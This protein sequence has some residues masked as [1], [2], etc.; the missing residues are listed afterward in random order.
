MP[1]DKGR[2]G[3]NG[4]DGEVLKAV[5]D[6]VKFL[7]A[8]AVGSLVFSWPI[9]LSDQ[10][11]VPGAKWC[12][13][14]AWGA[15]ALSVGAG[16]LTQS[17]LVVMLSKGNYNLDD[18]YLKWPGMIQQVLFAVGIILVGVSLFVIIL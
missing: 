1:D 18:N 15:L 9:I 4:H 13:A 10:A 8:L 14:S 5:S 2:G 7:I 16:L 3:S 17:R 6:F 11:G 12:L